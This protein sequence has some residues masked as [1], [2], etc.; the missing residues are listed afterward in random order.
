MAWLAY[1]I[2]Y[3]LQKYFSHIVVVSFSG[4]GN[5]STRRKQPTCGKSLTSLYVT[6]LSM[7]GTNNTPSKKYKELFIMSSIIQFKTNNYTFY[8]KFKKKL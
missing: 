5:R 7:I 8:T 6:T 2:I 3:H 1:G 4:G